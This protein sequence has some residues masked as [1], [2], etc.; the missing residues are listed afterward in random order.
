MSNADLI[1]STVAAT[2]RTAAE[3]G[4]QWSDESPARDELRGIADAVDAME[5][6]DMTCPVCEEAECDSDCPLV[7]VRAQS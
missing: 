6:D 1:R 7:S 4:L 5:P 2:L 3:W